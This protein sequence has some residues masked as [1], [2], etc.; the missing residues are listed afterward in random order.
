[1]KMCLLHPQKPG[2]KD[3]WD[4]NTPLINLASISPL[5]TIR[6]ITFIQVSHADI[7]SN[8][9][10]HSD[11]SPHYATDTHSLWSSLTPKHRTTVIGVN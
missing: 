6:H 5:F 10:V 1:M 3:V 11:R 7:D 8:E 9:K 2:K 4:N